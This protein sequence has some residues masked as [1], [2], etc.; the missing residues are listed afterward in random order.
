M[1][2]KII[3]L[4]RISLCFVKNKPGLGSQLKKNVA[5]WAWTLCISVLDPS[6]NIKP[7]QS[8]QSSSNLLPQSL[9]RSFHQVFWSKYCRCFFCTLPGTEAR[10][11][12]EE[13]EEQERGVT[14]LFAECRTYLNKIA[15]RFDNV[16][17]FSSFANNI[18]LP[19]GKASALLEGK[20]SACFSVSSCWLLL[21]K[22][23][24][25]QSN[26]MVPTSRTKAWCDICNICS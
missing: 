24:Q 4:H 3:V 17:C 10:E 6:K 9:H 12:T 7:H 11:G 22:N 21:S 5:V 18:C 23:V 26:E 20:G 8:F 25:Q 19:E 14:F 16:F 15:P 1:S 13:Q 2:S